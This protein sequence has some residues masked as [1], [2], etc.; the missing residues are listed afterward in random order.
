MCVIIWHFAGATLDVIDGIYCRNQMPSFCKR[1]EYQFNCP[2]LKLS[3]FTVRKALKVE[4][5]P[6]YPRQNQPTPKRGT[7]QKQ[8]LDWLEL[9]AKRPKRQRK[10]AQRLFECR[11]VEGYQGSYGPVQRF[12]LRWKQQ[13]GQSPSATKGFIPLSFPPGESCQF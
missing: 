7:F 10:T 5:E 4:S 11:Q 2:Q 6:I 12:V 3:R 8:L 1:R 13:A 9:D